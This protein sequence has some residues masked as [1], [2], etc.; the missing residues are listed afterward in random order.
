MI[1]N[2]AAEKIHYGGKNVKV[3]LLE[4]ELKKVVKVKKVSE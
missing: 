4:D 3:L 2:N 1:L